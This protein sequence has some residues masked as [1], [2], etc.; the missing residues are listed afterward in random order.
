MTTTKAE[1]IAERVLEA[2]IEWLPTAP[3][4]VR[5]RVRAATLGT[6]VYTI[7]SPADARRGWSEQVY[8][9]CLYQ[10]VLRCREAH[11]DDPER[12]CGWCAGTHVPKEGERR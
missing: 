6:K 8:G 5:R 7:A 10:Q 2:L 4:S 11:P 1:T 3:E 9:P 12:W